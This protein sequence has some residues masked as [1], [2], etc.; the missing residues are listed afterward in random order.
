[1][2]L[3][4]LQMTGFKSF[5]P[6]TKLEFEPGM[7]A[8]V[9][10]NGC[11]KSNIADAMRWVLGEQSAKALRGNKMEDVIFAGTDARKPLGMAEVNVTF[12]DCEKELGT[13]YHE[14]T[15]TRRVFRSGEGQYY[16]NKTAC[17]LK[18][19]RRLFMDT[20][21]GT[22][23]YSLMA[24]GRI[25]QILSSRPEDR[26]AVFE[27]ASGIT[28]FKADK[29][30]AI[31]KLEQTEANLLRLSD[32]IRE[33]KRQIGS[34]QRQAGK[35]RR[36]QTFREELKRLD[37][38]AARHHLG[39]FDGDIREIETEIAAM[40]ARIREAQQ[41]VEQHEQGNATIRET[42][43]QTEREIGTVLEAGVQARTQ[44]EH[45]RELIDVNGQRIEEYRQLS[46][47]DNREIENAR[48]QIEKHGAA[49]AALDG[50]LA[51]VSTDEAEAEKSMHVHQAA[52]DSHVA[53]IETVRKGVQSLREETVALESAASRLQNQLGEIE[54]HERAA[55]V[56][57]ERLTAEQSQLSRAAETQQHRRSEQDVTLSQLRG[58]VAT[59][60]DA[61]AAAEGALQASLATLEELRQAC[62]ELR[63][64]MAAASTRVDLLSAE[65]DAESFPAGARVLLDHGGSLDVDPGAVLGPLATQVD[66]DPDY[67]RAFETVIRA[68]VDAVVVRDGATAR[69]ILGALLATGAGSA[70]LL[71]S[72]RDPQ[73]ELRNAV[74]G[75]RLMDHVRAADAV[76]GLLESLIGHVAV[77]DGIA[78]IPAD[79]PP[80]A[81]Y[82]TR[83]GQLVS[84]PA[85][86][87]LWMPVA[88]G[89]NP[90]TR[91]HALDE[92][93]RTSEACE[94]ELARQEAEITRVAAGR[95]R[96]SAAVDSA[97]QELA[98]VERELA[99]REGEYQMIC[100]EADEAARRL[101][102]VT[103]E[104]DSLAGDGASENT[105]RQDVS[106]RLTETQE[107]RGELT[108]LVQDQ[109]RE[110]RELEDGSIAL[111]SKL[112]DSRIQHIGIR[113]RAE[114]LAAQ[115]ESLAARVDEL[116][117][118]VR[119]RSEGLQSYEQ[120]IA[121]L[122]REITEAHARLG[123]LETAVRQNEERAAS[124]R[125][126]Q[127]KQAGEL[128]KMETL[129]T[130]RRARSD[131]LREAL[132]SCE[133]RRSEARMQ[134]QNLLDRVTS[135]Y[136]I[137]A[138]EV[139]KEPEP[140]EDP[141]PPLDEAETRIAELRAKL[142][143]M[144]PVNLVAI[145]EYNELEQRHAFLTEQ[146]Q[147]LVNSKQQLME[148]IRKINRTTSEMFSETFEKVN[149]NFDAVFKKLFQ[150]GSARLVL[151]DEDDILDSGVEIIA[152][153]PGKR[154]QNI[155]LLSGGERTLTA[156]S[157]LFAIYMIKP[158]PFCMLDEL[159]AAL[160][161]S[162]IGRFV[163]ILK[164]FLS[165]SQFVVITH[166]R[167][168]IAAAD[169]LYGITMQEKG[170]SSVVS[171]KFSEAAE[172]EDWVKPSTV[173]A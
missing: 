84:G 40:G 81:A 34:L 3:K 50:A 135:D 74:S 49:L 129:L 88:G 120:S 153:P 93:R 13:D 165:Q 1:M 46:Q 82:V 161:D 96:H 113:Q 90:L 51:E 126:N 36:Y 101:E 160:D 119:G 168:T 123:S 133:I 117:A 171:M 25:D 124:L 20:G 86:A 61:R 76:R 159:D 111:Q 66:I 131:A 55:V 21:V 155:S 91:R 65:D 32:V 140:G 85:T 125:R 127:E 62:G 80:G 33:V 8:I 116:D 44:L 56:R 158:S 166:N 144:G 103:W 31:S 108:V 59:R 102:T 63:S 104:L 53:R 16:L 22:S 58:A 97:R 92:A 95:A 109:L 70:R 7:T 148:M 45:T 60:D 147:D 173:G 100:R 15:I 14:V 79:V 28:K 172:H 43:M 130:E 105:Q 89:G 139:L 99:Q 78:D 24:Q 37:L 115:R 106:T 19:V 71:I 122:E 73:P 145:E 83:E 170:V 5:L 77:V 156:V 10:P 41:E 121:R 151:V 141:L 150:G 167:Q 69:A 39:A 143:A 35:A 134:R 132:S 138:D 48:S 157:L 67:R 94:S 142:E 12:S 87:E 29:T 2:Y 23:S 38:Y 18:D 9:G 6:K 163:T 47:R 30:E 136:R 42:Q 17:R 26:R 4:E 152:R 114:H 11:G 146:E 164:S 64:R 149:A 107:R 169:V 162:N 27:E 57:R 72:A 68:W 52:F 110:L 128:A 137:A 118:N 98:G 112:T 54:T 75:N 154:L